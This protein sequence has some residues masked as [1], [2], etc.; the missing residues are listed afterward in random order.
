MAGPRPAPD[1]RLAR[2]QRAIMTASHRT[3]LSPRPQFGSASPFA[4][5]SSGRGGVRPRLPVLKS[6]LGAEPPSGVGEATARRH[7]A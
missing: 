6:Y 4:T 7:Q 2:R 1:P 3:Y 5:R